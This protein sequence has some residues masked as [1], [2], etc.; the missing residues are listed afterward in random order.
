MLSGINTLRRDNLSQYDSQVTLHRR[1]RELHMCQSGQTSL[2]AVQP[3]DL[4]EK[5]LEKQN[6]M[7]WLR[8]YHKNLSNCSKVRLISARNIRK[9]LY[10]ITPGSDQIVPIRTPPPLTPSHYRNPYS[11]AFKFVLEHGVGKLFEN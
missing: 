3:P 7:R 5:M 9:K 8:L 1:V 6:I 11:V 2:Q 10:L 4:P